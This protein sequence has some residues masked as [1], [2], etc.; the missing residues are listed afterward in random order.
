MFCKKTEANSLLIKK[1]SSSNSCFPLSFSM[2]FEIPRARS[3]GVAPSPS[4]KI[5][6]SNV[7]PAEKLP[8]AFFS[9]VLQESKS[10]CIV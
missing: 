5:G 7:V 3:M 2:R 10:C 9:G 8:N 6:T 4:S 1:S